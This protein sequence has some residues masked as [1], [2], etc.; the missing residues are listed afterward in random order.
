MLFDH[1]KQKSER[2]KIWRETGALTMMIAL[3]Q[4]KELI[5]VRIPNYRIRSNKSQQITTMDLFG[6]GG[7]Y[8][9]YGYGRNH[10]YGSK[11]KSKHSKGREDESKKKFDT[12]Q[13]TMEVRHTVLAKKESDIVC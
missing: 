3:N 8:D 6:F 9:G 11:E 5:D 4:E 10:W 13:K 2:V 12:M 1:Q 7:F